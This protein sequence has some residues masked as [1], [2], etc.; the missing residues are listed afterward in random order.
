MLHKEWFS[1]WFDTKY[2]ALLYQ[3]RNDDEAKMFVNNIVKTIKPSKASKVLDMGCG[4]GRF[5]RFLHQYDMKVTGIDI[6]PT[7]IRKAV[8]SSPG[9]I[10]FET[11]DIREPYKENTFDYIYSFF[12]SF[13]YFDTDEE[14]LRTI[15]NVY[16]SLKIH[17]VFLLD[18]LNADRVSINLPQ[19]NELTISGIHYKIHKYKKDNYFIKDIEIDDHGKAYHFTE[20]VRAFTLR[21]FKTMFVKV[22]L[23]VIACYGDY[24]LNNFDIL[25]SK[26]LIIMGVKR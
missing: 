11:H 18:Y 1:S 22:G 13:G 25:K 16:D 6:S 20:K 17:G 3:D 14:H 10:V 8:I 19:R 24:E 26:R 12:T 5:S 23:Q 4:S 21:D 7:V 9:D 15:K 2:Y